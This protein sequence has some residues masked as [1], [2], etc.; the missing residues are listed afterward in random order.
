MRLALLISPGCVSGRNNPPGRGEPLYK[1]ATAGSNPAPGS[2]MK[3]T[4]AMPVMS[5][6]TASEDLHQPL[7]S[8]VDDK[9]RPRNSRGFRTL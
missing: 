5:S 8:Q 9:T 3:Y 2:T 7:T 4:R 6:K 1:A